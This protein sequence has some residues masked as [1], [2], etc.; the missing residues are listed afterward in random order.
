[1]SFLL[2]HCRL[3]SSTRQEAWLLKAETSQLTA[4]QHREAAFLPQFQLRKHFGEELPLAQLG[5]DA[6]LCGQGDG[7][8][9]E[10][11]LSQLPASRGQGWGHGGMRQL[12]L[13]PHRK[14]GG[15]AI[16]NRSGNAHACNFWDRRVVL[17]CSNFL[18]MVIAI[19]LQA[20]SGCFQG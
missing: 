5:C 4:F 2:P 3:A 7:Y 11:G 14:S 15:G 20:L 17:L 6:Y 9:E 8:H 12:S 18:M 19:W 13:Q 16:S 1:M 10:P